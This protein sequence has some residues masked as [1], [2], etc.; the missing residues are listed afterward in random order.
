MLSTP[1]AFVLSQ[2]QT[3]QDILKLFDSSF[4]FVVANYLAR[5]F[6]VGFNYVKP[7]LWLMFT[8]FE[9]ITFYCSVFKDQLRL[10]NTVLWRLDYNNRF[11]ISCQQLFLIFFSFNTLTSMNA[12]F[13]RTCLIVYS[14]SKQKSTPN[15]KFL[16][17]SSICI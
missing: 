16:C 5:I 2:D 8:S 13:S 17:P 4:I 3:L 14:I 12:Q 11:T 9:V 7:A 10:Y 1:P 6:L 15:F